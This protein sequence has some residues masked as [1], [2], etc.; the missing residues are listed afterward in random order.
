MK[1][2]IKFSIFTLI[3][4]IAFSCNKKKTKQEQ[5][6]TEKIQYDVNIKS[7][8]S[9]LEWWIQNIEG[10]QRDRF[11]NSLFNAIEDNKVKIFNMNQREVSLENIISNLFTFDTIHLLQKNGRKKQIIDTVFISNSFNIKNVTKFRFDEKWTL[12]EKTLQVD[13]EI[14]GFCPILVGKKVSNIAPIELPLFWVY[15]DTNIK[16]DTANNFLITKKIQYDVFIKSINKEEDW[17]AENIEATDRERFLKTIIDVAA[18]GKLKAYDFFMNPLDKKKFAKILHRTDTITLQRL[19]EP[20]NDY[21][22]VIK[23][24]F[25]QKSIVKMRFV[26]EW[27][28]NTKSFRFHKKVLAIC[29]IVEGIDD[30]GNVRGYTPLFWM[31]FDESIRTTE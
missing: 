10:P 9:D 1:H 15:P 27:T 6:V 18:K 11:V 21:D 4:F 14:K 28:M 13:K 8:D 17:W 30:K 22:T 7:T 19:T 24:D 23:T 29:P 20:Y 16:S 12:N 5:L 3:I 26:E 2:L 25:D 31:F